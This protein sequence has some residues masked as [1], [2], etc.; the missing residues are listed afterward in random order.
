MRAINII[1]TFQSGKFSSIRALLK[2]G[3]DINRP[4]SRIGYPL[5]HVA[6]F[7]RNKVLN[8]LLHF[9]CNIF[10]TNERHQNILHVA[11]INENTKG[12]I[13]FLRNVHKTDALKLLSA[14]DDQG[15]TPLHYSVKNCDYAL[16][17]YFIKNGASLHTLD[18]H[19]QSPRFYARMNMCEPV[20]RLL[21]D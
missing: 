13:L 6:Q 8:L 21:Q 3:Y 11:S 16:S 18:S 5:L 2:L 1:K 19:G 15:R 17:K 10:V 20:L 12:A 7:K 4:I 14:K 9:R